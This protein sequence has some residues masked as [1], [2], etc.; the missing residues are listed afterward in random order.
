MGGSSR[1]LISEALLV[2]LTI[3][4]LSSIL[5]VFISMACIEGSFRTSGRQNANFRQLSSIFAKFGLSCVRIF[6]NAEKRFELIT[7]SDAARSMDHRP[8]LTSLRF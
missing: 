8:F 5:E 3:F 1:Y 4:R 2:N 6:R 7:L